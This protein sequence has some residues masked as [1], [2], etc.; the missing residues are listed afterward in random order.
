M[1]ELE[2][3]YD[4][5]GRFKTPN[6]TDGPGNYNMSIYW[7]IYW[8][9]FKHPRTAEYNSRWAFLRDYFNNDVE[10]NIISVRV[11]NEWEIQRFEEL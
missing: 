4:T 2:M 9:L 8:G 11:H 1:T 3:L 5:I 6:Y 10:N 7:N